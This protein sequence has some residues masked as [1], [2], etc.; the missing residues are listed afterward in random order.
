[1]FRTGSKRIAN[2]A[3]QRL[4]EQE[5]NWKSVNER[6]GLEADKRSEGKY[7]RMRPSQIYEEAYKELKDW[8]LEKYQRRYESEDLSPSSSY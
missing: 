4:I 8:L 2:E 5:E 3:H 6:W 7:F 1:M